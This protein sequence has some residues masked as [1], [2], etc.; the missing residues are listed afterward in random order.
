MLKHR[1]QLSGPDSPDQSVDDPGELL[2][3][4]GDD[5]RLA[6]LELQRLPTDPDGEDDLATLVRPSPRAHRQLPLGQHPLAVL[7]LPSLRDTDVGG[8]LQQ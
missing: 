6:L 7:F 8:V 1:V 3:R 2:H 5:A 4:P